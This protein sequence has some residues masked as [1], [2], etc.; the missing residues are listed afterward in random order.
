[1]KLLNKIMTGLTVLLIGSTAL[2]GYSLVYSS[3]A[4]AVNLHV[5]LA[6]A[7]LIFTLITLALLVRSAKNNKA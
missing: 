5:L 7:T 6:T 3:T 4:E 2:C 1:M